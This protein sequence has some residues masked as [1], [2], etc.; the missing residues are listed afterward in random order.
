MGRHHLNERPPK[1]HFRL[2]G[3]AFPRVKWWKDA[4]MKV[5]YFYILALILTNTYGNPLPPSA[6][7]DSVKCLIR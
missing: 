1:G 6:K 4:Q 3:K 5:L 2:A 7:P